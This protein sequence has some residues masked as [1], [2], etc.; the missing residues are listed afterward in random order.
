[1]SK[2]YFIPG[3]YDGCFYYRTYLPCVYGNM[4]FPKSRIFSD[5]DK[6]LM[7]LE[8]MEADIIVMQRPN[9]IRRYEIAKL[10]KIKG[11]KIIFENDDTYL[12]DKGVPLSMLANDK[13]R[14]IAKKMNESLYKTIKIS[15]GVIASTEFLADEYRKLNKNVVVLKNCIDPLDSIT[16]KENKTGKFRVGFIG[17]VSSNDDYT[18]IKDDIKK[19]DNRGDITIVVFGVK[20]YKTNNVCI[21]YKDDHDFWSSLK[22]VEWQSFVPITD[23]YNTIANLALDLVI[24]PRK[25]SYFNRCKSNLKF[26]EAS[27]LK[28]PVLAQGFKDGKSPY[29]S[30]KYLTIEYDDW[31][32]RIVEIKEN[33]HKYAKQAESAY[34]Y[35]IKNYNINDYAEKWKSTI[36][37]LCK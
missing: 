25:D 31:Y 12:P 3:D 8:A 1:M 30:D 32:N 21:G 28:I 22:N 35:V 2:I 29:Q 26:L 9:D 10:L 18:H 23:Y 19:L 34:N 14:E 27:L 16:K 33:Y 4:G 36:E 15:D 7:F 6:E 24:I 13:Q 11:K 20:Q 5:L 37:K 17:S